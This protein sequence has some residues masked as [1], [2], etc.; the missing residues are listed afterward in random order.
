MKIKNLNV[1]YHSSLFALKTFLAFITLFKKIHEI[2]KMKITVQDTDN[3][4][5]IYLI[6]LQL[7]KVTFFLPEYLWVVDGCG[8]KALV[9]LVLQHRPVIRILYEIQSA[10]PSADLKHYIWHYNKHYRLSFESF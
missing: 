3:E 10:S 2:N 6:F 4:E 7:K 1:T 9:D 8:G 5:Q